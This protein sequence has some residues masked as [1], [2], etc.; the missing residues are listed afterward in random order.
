MLPPLAPI[1][2][3]YGGRAA[4][5]SKRLRCSVAA[6]DS[7]EPEAIRRNVARF[8]A[9]VIR[10]KPPLPFKTGRPSYAAVSITIIYGV[11]GYIWPQSVR[12]ESLAQGHCADGTNRLR[13]PTR[14]NGS[15]SSSRAK[16]YCVVVASFTSLD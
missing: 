3:G 9:V 8:R 10:F 4:T 12:I 7:P 6:A 16:D 14:E 2:T 13:K 1:C 5:V 11:A 15:G